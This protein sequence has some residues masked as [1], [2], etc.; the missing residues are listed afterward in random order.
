MCVEPVT[1]FKSMATVRQTRLAMEAKQDSQQR[2]MG[3]TWET[4]TTDIPV[5]K[6][7][8]NA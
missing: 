4:E 8:E 3:H 2:W 7:V 1:K 5:V 6:R